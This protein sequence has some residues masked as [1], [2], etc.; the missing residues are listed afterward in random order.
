MGRAFLFIASF[1]AAAAAISLLLAAFAFNSPTG[2]RLIADIFERELGEALDADVSIASLGGAPPHFLRFNS[3]VINRNSARLVE[4]DEIEMKWSPLRLLRREIAIDRL[5]FNGATIFALPPEKDR[6]GDGFEL[7]EALPRLSIGRLTFT[8]ILFAE[9][10]AGAPLR[11][12]GA[13]ALAMRGESFVAKLDAASSNNRDEISI[14]I[15]RTDNGAAPVLDV[16]VASRVDG[17]LAA[18]A[19][20]DGPISIEITGAGSTHAYRTDFA[21]ELGGYGSLQGRSD[22]DLT[23]PIKS[24]VTA[25]GRLG[26]RF[27]AAR[28]ELGESLDFYGVVTL[29]DTLMVLSIDSLRMAI[30]EGSGR[31][32]W[33]RATGDVSSPTM[34]FDLSVLLAKSWRPELQ[35]YV[36][37]KALLNGRLTRAGKEYEGDLS[38]ETPLALFRST[39][40]RS[41]LRRFWRGPAGLVVKANSAAP[42]VMRSGVSATG[43][44]ELERD[45]PLRMT[46]LAAETMNGAR[47]RGDVAYGLAT[48]NF[49][50]QGDVSLSPEFA[51]ALSSRIKLAGPATARLTLARQ[52]DSYLARLA[53]V[54][55]NLAIDGRTIGP[56][57]HAIAL[58]GSMQ[59]F[60]GTIA[61]RSLKGPGS[62]KS[63]IARKPSGE[64]RIFDLLYEGR[65]FALAGGGAIDRRAKAAIIDLRYKG[66]AG[67]EPFPGVEI[68]GEAFATG[69]INADTKPNKI[70]IGIPR[71]STPRFAIDDLRAVVTG[72]QAALRVDVGASGAKFPG[73]VRVDDL[74]ATL[75]FSAADPELIT[76]SALR[77]RINEAPAHLVR[78][79]TVTLGDAFMVTPVSLSFDRGGSIEFAGA[80]SRARWRLSGVLRQAPLFGGAAIADADIDLDTSKS[81]P[82]NGSVSITAAFDQSNKAALALKFTWDGRTIRLANADHQSTNIVN[83]AMPLPLRRGPS[84]GV[85]IPDRIDGLIIYE[86]RIEPVSALLPAFAQSLEGNLKLEG[87]ITGTL[88]NPVLSGALRVSN[89]ALTD[90][91]SGVSIINIEGE[92][93]ARTDE[94]GSRIDFAFDGSGPR[95]SSKSITAAGA[96]RFADG[97]VLDSKIVLDGAQLSAGPIELVEASGAFNLSGPIGRLTATGSV[98]VARLNAILFEAQRTGLVDI[99]VLRPGVN[100]PFAATAPAQPAPPI[101]YSLRAAANDEVHIKG[102]GLVSEWKALATIEGVAGRPLLLGRL[103]L[104]DGHLRLGGRRISLTQG[105]IEFDRLSSNDPALDLR[106]ERR[107]SQGAQVS[108]VVRGRASAPEITVEAS[109]AMPRE[110][111]MALLLF[112]RPMNELTALQSLQVADSLSELGGVGLIGGKGIAAT[113][114]SALGLDLLDVEIDEADSAASVLTV[115]KYVTD[116]LFVSASQD[117]RGEAGSVTIEYQINNSFSIETALR[118]DGDQTI[119]A[120]WK[121]DF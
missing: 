37:E 105:L 102:R 40:F 61:S 19:R 21:A 24:A 119:S 86:G 22:A 85:Q 83:L 70:E 25:S 55:P 48:R 106:A 2:R 107:V 9:G 60:G 27:E 59:E 101:S 18:L 50:L 17:A 108:I 75:A 13:G 5:S 54:T 32:A 82:A 80:C 30:G 87:E 77:A 46:A 41:D 52:T 64:W 112:D 84:I 43:A 72:P 62:L 117:A 29:D 57:S 11:L 89:G 76:L 81:I 88:K 103:E 44:L 94:T 56:A 14:T 78:P 49:D 104:I 66:D 35:R 93:K 20:S 116:G 16:R 47:F 7:P 90:F 51:Q 45:K 28:K 1:V 39:G 120:N 31:I 8:N 109:P 10:V 26:P 100:E 92:A 114:R 68:S 99:H 98:D 113:A 96:I 4:F 91:S 110:D 111:A 63:R 73:A 33:T 71:L 121:K 67:A 95:Q 15:E 74:A 53:G 36:G 23:S 42:V 34:E 12:D 69:K 3:L 118:Q 115:G 65:G 58:S 38:A 6:S 97:A 79:A